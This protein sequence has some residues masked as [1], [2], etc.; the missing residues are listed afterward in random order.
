MVW[1]PPRTWVDEEL[2][3]ATILN[4]HLRDQLGHL[5][6]QDEGI[7]TNLA[8]Q[9]LGRDTGFLCWPAGDTGAPAHY[10]YTG[11]GA[12]MTR[13][14]FGLGDPTRYVSR[15]CARI[16]SAASV[17]GTLQQQLLP[18]SVFPSQLRGLDVSI[19][20]ALK[21][22]TPL[23]LRAGI[24]DGVGTEYTP[25]ATAEFAWFTA[26]RTLHSTSATEL[27]LRVEIGAGAVAGYVADWCVV[28]GRTAPTYPQP[29]RTGRILACQTQVGGLEVGTFLNRW[30]YPLPMPAVLRRVD[31]VAGTAPTGGPAVWDVNKN[32]VS[33]YATKPQ[34]ASGALTGGGAPDAAY[35][36]RCFARGDVLSYDQDTVGVTTPGADVTASFDLLCFLSP[37]DQ[38]LSVTDVA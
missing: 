1:T 36:S 23:K 12:T 17:A 7:M 26:T 9:N 25:F 11:A 21:C 38:M 24:F 33:M 31:V 30:R 4:T 10:T 18:P 20:V 27:T 6:G 35:A 37:L 34:I 32:N 14:G 13:V 5:F 15:F 3:T 28:L 16:I 8:A 2:V 19:G 29:C 22:A